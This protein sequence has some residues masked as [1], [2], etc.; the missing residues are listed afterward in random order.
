[1]APT[2][3]IVDDH[4]GFRAMARRMLEASG[5]T[6]TGEAPDAASGLLAAAAQRPDV[7]LLDLNLPDASGLEVAGRLAA[8]GPAVVLCSTHEEEELGDLARENGASGF[9]PKSQLTG[10]TLAS[11]ARAG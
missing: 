7:V 6:V 5:W 9:V 3:L 8:G 11:A 10:E 1:M 4:A 2:V